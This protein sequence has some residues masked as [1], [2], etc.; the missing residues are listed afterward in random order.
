M[1]KNLPKARTSEILIQELENELL[2][3]DLRINKAFCLNETSRLVWQLCDG[4]NSVADIAGLMSRKLKINVSE[5]FVWLALDGLKKD[6]LLEKADEFEIDFAG[7]NRREVIRRVGLASMVTLPIIAS[8][9]APSALMAQS[10]RALLSVGDAG[11]L[12]DLDCQ[13]GG[14]SAACKFATDGLRHC[15]TFSGGVLLPPNIIFNNGMAVCVPNQT[16][17]DG[18]GLQF[19]CRGVASATFSADCV[20]SLACQCI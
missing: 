14:V 4:T 18:V 8:V 9:V 12:S 13:G 15:C 7:L 11:C 16:F 17:C 5:E 2:I 10:G 6:D 3:Y 19:C 20:N 1:T